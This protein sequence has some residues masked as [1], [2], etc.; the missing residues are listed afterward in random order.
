MDIRIG[1]DIRLNIAIS[2]FDILPEETIKCAHCFLMSETEKNLI[3]V[4]PKPTVL[5]SKYTLHHSNARIYNVLPSNVQVRPLDGPGFFDKK[6]RQYGKLIFTS[7]SEE[8]GYIY[9]FFQGREQYITGDYYLVVML[10]LNNNGYGP[11]NNRHIVVDYGYV[12]TISKEGNT[13]NSTGIDVASA[14]C[15][16]SES[17][18]EV[19]DFSRKLQLP[20]TASVTTELSDKKKCH[21]I[22]F[23]TS[24]GYICSSIVDGD[25]DDIAVDD[26]YS[27]E[28]D[29]YTVYYYLSPVNISD[30]TTFTLTKQTM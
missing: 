15:G 10:V 2:D 8:N 24:S 16:T 11:F 25:G 28:I 14:Y 1:N 29:E 3:N 26:I 5:P 12:F 19:L 9:G 13:V 4:D 30:T 23:K 17:E 22:A 21:W 18:P 6:F 20:C 27:K 7:V